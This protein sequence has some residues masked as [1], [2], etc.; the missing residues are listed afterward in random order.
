MTVLPHADFC[1]V[2]GSW[3]ELRKVSDGRY[4]GCEWLKPLLMPLLALL[5]LSHREDD[6]TARGLQDT[7]SQVSRQAAE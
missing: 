5:R 2:W 7:C 3:H 6:L 4:I 1:H